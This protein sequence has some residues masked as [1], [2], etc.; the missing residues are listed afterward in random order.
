[1]TGA[2]SADSRISVTS[3]VESAASSSS[4]ETASE[5]ALSSELR[6]LIR[7][8][9]STSAATATRQLRP[10]IICTSSTART[11][12]GIRHRQEEG[13]GVDVADRNRVEATGRLHRD[14]VR[15][16][17]VDVVAVEVDVI[18]A[19]ALGDR[20]RELVGA[21]HPLLDHQCLRGAS[22]GARLGDRLVDPIGGEIAELDHDIGD[23]ATAVGAGSRCGQPGWAAL[24]W[25]GGES[26]GPHARRRHRAQ[27][28][29]T[30]GWIVHHCC[31]RTASRMMSVDGSRPVQMRNDSAPWQTRISSPSTKVAP[32]LM[33]VAASSV[34]S[35]P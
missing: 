13:V 25:L 35:D 3:A 27:I 10:V 16:A 19:V 17:H 6:R 28:A 26:F 18:E 7:S 30:I 23:E 4:S 2:S 8:S 1:M 14:Q 33:H 34:G 5:T 9:M 24:L 21:E 12:A 31:S 15:R 32:P 11:L 22:G 29:R 20:P